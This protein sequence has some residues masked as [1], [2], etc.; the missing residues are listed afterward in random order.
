ML[1]E[2]LQSFLSAFWV[3]RVTFLDT[4]FLA[5]D[6][7]RGT[8]CHE[9]PGRYRISARLRRHRLTALKYHRDAAATRYRKRAARYP[10]HRRF[11]DCA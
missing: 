1:G 8:K 2:I 10:A 7:A 4:S 3:T 5:E 9:S 11:F 6:I